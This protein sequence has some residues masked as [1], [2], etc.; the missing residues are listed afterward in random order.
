M[1]KHKDFYVVVYDIA[2]AKPRRKI[3][4]ILE[5]Y[6]HRVNKSVFECMVTPTEAFK[7]KREISNIL[8]EKKDS[9]VFYPICIDCYSKAEY[10]PNNQNSRS[11][12]KVIA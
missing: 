2:V 10:Y 1:R 11:V 8:N 7:M 4:A 3:A 9:V 6:G 5:R 12:V